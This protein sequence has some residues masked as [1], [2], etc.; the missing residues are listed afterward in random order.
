MQLWKASIWNKIEKVKN[1][2]LEN[3][4]KKLNHKKYRPKYIKSPCKNMQF[5]KRKDI[6]KIRS[7][8]Q[9]TDSVI[10]VR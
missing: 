2:Y 4:T 8:A 3:K 10:K 5:D 9:V 7:S 6:L 1:I